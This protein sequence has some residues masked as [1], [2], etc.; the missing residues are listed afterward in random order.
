MNSNTT[1]RWIPD[2]EAISCHRC[3][4]LFDWTYRKH[5]CRR[6]GHVF[7]GSCTK[8]SLIRKE[9]I[10]SNPEKQYLS[11]NPHNP[12]RVCYQ[13]YHFMQPEQDALR[14]T[15]SNA[16]REN[17]LPEGGNRALFN[18]PFSFTMRDEIRKASYSIQA[19]KNQ[20][21]IKDQCIPLPL[22][23][24]AKG[25]VFMTVLKA[26]M[27]FSARLGTGLVIAKLPDGI[28]SAP[29]AIGTAGLGWGAQIG[30]ELTDVIIILNTSQ[31]VEAFSSSTQVNLGAEL[32][33]ATGFVGRVTSGS[34]GTSVDGTAPC[35]SYSHSRGL[36][37]GISLEGAV[38]IS[39][40]DINHTFYGREVTNTQLL[41]GLEFPPNAATPLYDALQTIVSG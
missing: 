4:Q 38:I 37:A 14:K 23:R 34:L 5:H 12:Q 35:Y 36:F 31:A 8:Q 21:A 28:W 11:I 20:D 33:V 29:S 7:C 15:T 41:T 3:Q 2:G 6:C 26:G 40:P 30:A 27:I 1:L 9:H 24:N 39:R 25:L 17:L 18:S 16:S 13:C 10:L 19:I 32:G 22:L